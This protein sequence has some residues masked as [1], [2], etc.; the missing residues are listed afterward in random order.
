[1][2]RT[3]VY[4]KRNNPQYHLKEEFRDKESE[5][6]HG[7]PREFFNGADYFVDRNI[8][9]GRGHRVAVYTENRKYT[10]NDIQKMVNKT[11]NAMLDLGLRID[12][13]I[14]LLMLDVPQFYAIFWGAMKIGAIPIP[15]NTMLTPEDYEYYLNDSRA[16]VLAVSEELL[17]VIHQIR[18][19]L[20]Y[21]RDL[22][23]I[24][25]KEGAHIPFRQKYKRAPA[26]IKPAI[27]TRDDVG[28]W[29]YSSG[30]TG[31][32]KGAIHSQYDIVVTSRDYA[33]GVLR[34]T[35]NDICFSAARLFFAY[36]LGNGMYFPMSVGASAVLSPYR[37]TPE[38]IFRYLKQFRPTLFFGIP[39]LYGQML[40]YKARQ[41]RE[42][43]I[44]PDP[45]TDHE[46]SSVRLCISAGE[47]L[48]PDIYF[49][50]KQRF[51]VDILDGIGSTEMLHIFLSNQSGSIRPGSTGKP[52]PGYELKLMDEDGR[53]VPQ[54][55]I[56][57]LMVR[58]DSAAQFYWR[59]RE[60]TRK[61]MQGEW[62]NTGDKYYMDK[63]GYYWCAGRSDDML[64]VGGIWV[65]P[66]EVEN[67][68]VEHRAVLE[69]AI[70]GRKDDQGLI[71]PKAFVVLREG[72]SPSEALAEELKEWVQERLAKYKYPRW[73]DFIPELPKSATGKIQRFR[74]R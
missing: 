48:P 32:P 2:S 38:V 25:E 31:P 57:T 65:S 18:G 72:I 37:P 60:K 44:Q 17:P 16:R 39:T 56:G 24:S 27:T 49:R 54:G 4:Q 28:F 45:D 61:T 11:A 5:V 55:E 74:L 43:G 13:R 30:S 59:R 69:S 40:E 19:D 73:I 41:D 26:L 64:K 46:L 33:R 66:V 22:I 47:A 14:I 68:L 34:I 7:D 52:V 29:L 20:Y 71:K 50:W 53:E 36:G 1:L 51:G 70:V 10:Y 35:E 42:R 21:L 58:G 6:D 3:R 8:R 62:I 15:V 63:E 67:C 23:V 12:E 9:Q